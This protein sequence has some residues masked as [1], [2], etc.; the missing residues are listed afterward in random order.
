MRKTKEKQIG[1]RGYVYH[2]TQFGAR[3]GGRI[4]I[5]LG[6][7]FGGALG[8]AIKSDTERDVGDMIAKAF[9]AVTEQDFDALIDTFA[10][11]SAVSGGDYKGQAPLTAEG[12][13]DLHFAGAYGELVQWLIFAFEVNF[14]SFLGE[15]GI[16]P[17]GK[18]AASDRPVSAARAG[19]APSKSRSPNTLETNGRSGA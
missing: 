11:C 9:D 2:V 19:T 15:A 3:E 12:L 10:K 1:D 13:F 6:K 17:S 5:R 18:A 7:I 14:G 16:V 4:A 8:A